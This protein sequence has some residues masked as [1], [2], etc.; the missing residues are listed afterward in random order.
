V[1]G[2]AIDSTGFGQ[3]SVKKTCEHGNEA[4]GTVM[5]GT[6]YFTGHHFVKNDSLCGVSGFVSYLK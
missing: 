5:R 1:R 2:C 3:G 6:D 4:S